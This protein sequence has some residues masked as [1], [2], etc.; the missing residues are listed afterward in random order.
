M[1]GIIADDVTGAH[2]VASMVI[3]PDRRVDVF[4]DRLPESSDE[5]P[6]IAIVDTHSREIASFDAANKVSLA[7]EALRERGVKQYYKKI[8]SVFRGNIGVEIGAAMEET[9]STSTV[10]VPAFPQ[11]NRHTREGYH[12]VGDELLHRSEVGGREAHLASSYLP[13]ML[14]QQTT[15]PVELI[16]LESVRRGAAALEQQIG[17]LASPDGTMIIVDAE[18]DGDIET[19]A[20]A[21][22]KQTLAC[23]SASLA[24]AWAEVRLPRANRTKRSFKSPDI[25]A[26]LI[27]SGTCS[28]TAQA[29]CREAAASGMTICEVWKNP[30]DGTSTAEAAESCANGLAELLRSGKDAVLRWS[31]LSPSGE[32]RASS[33]IAEVLADIAAE[34]ASHV[35]AFVMTGG[36]CAGTAMRRLGIA[37]TEVIESFEPGIAIALS[38]GTDPKLLVLKPGSYGNASFYVRAARRL[39]ELIEGH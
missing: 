9:K 24:D 15:H 22:R 34:V 32:T 26:V 13:V 23:G 11:N 4:L 7:F 18:E 20:R 31:S 39:H 8:C 17:A 30:S 29:Q 2:D 37:G 28:P 12:Y 35:G 10:V 3:R 21:T 36:H 33:R 14:I 5:S 27:L 1:L 38:K 16:H 25:D 19:I 6:D